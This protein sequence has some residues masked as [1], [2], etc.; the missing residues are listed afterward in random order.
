[1]LDT[2]FILENVKLSSNNSHSNTTLLVD[3]KS[4]DFSKILEKQKHV[5]NKV[6]HSY[7]HNKNPID[8]VETHK[9]TEKDSIDNKL[10]TEKEDEIEE[11]IIDDLLVLINSLYQILDELSF[12]L[13][14][15]EDMSQLQLD[16]ESIISRLG[17]AID[18]NLDPEYIIEELLEDV[19]DLFLKKDIHLNQDTMD[20]DNK[21]IAKEMEQILTELNKLK[22][23]IKP[24]G[25]RHKSTIEKSYG[26]IENLD[27]LRN[28]QELAN[29]QN[30]E[31]GVEV[32][33]DKNIENKEEMFEEKN[34]NLREVIA[35]D[36]Q[37][38]PQEQSTEVLETNNPILE[39]VD[40]STSM[41][42]LEVREQDLKEISQK[43]LF[44]QIVDKVKL[45]QD[46][47]KQ[48]IRIKLK[49]EILG[50][51]MLRM[52]MEKGDV[53]AKI[54]VDNYRTKE[55]LETNLYQLKEDMRENG[56][57]IK[58]FEVFVGTN[59][60][61]EREGRQEFYLNR[62]NNKFKINNKEIDGVETY[63]NN[64]TEKLVGLYEGGRL[65]LLA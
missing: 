24:T 37:E 6:E 19:E 47:F 20:A 34:L 42:N 5:Q 17:H 62:K 31:V 52:E 7:G 32:E 12:D 53:V 55:I 56:L 41:E 40:R 59:E 51:L 57:E 48:E 27:G 45:I 16:L 22:T 23:N 46:D 8:K 13:E 44:K 28:Q 21:I 15:T 43:D 25:V 18:E 64:T 36:V 9:K 1:M 58:T 39:M 60:D 30:E 38:L 29:I 4:K 49:P 14:N 11:S 3:D 26:G 50:E 10:P 61:F 2:S 63:V 33:P 35:D 54:M 65:N